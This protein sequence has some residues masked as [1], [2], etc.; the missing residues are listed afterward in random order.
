M[1]LWI[2]F[3][4]EMKRGWMPEDCWHAM[5]WQSP[6]RVRLIGSSPTLKGSR[7]LGMI[8]SMWVAVCGCLL[9]ALCCM[10]I[11]WGTA[12]CKTG[13][14]Q[15]KMEKGHSE[16]TVKGGGEPKEGVGKGW[17]ERCWRRVE[18]R[19]RSSAN[20]VGRQ[21]AALKMRAR[22][23]FYNNLIEGMMVI[24]QETWHVPIWLNRVRGEW[25]W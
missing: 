16:R 23:E 3:Y 6:L 12:E 13:L 25:L 20:L 14:F 7:W 8:R 19:S 24:I 1:F 18:K 15:V 2:H 10:W 17:R 22:Q 11:L 9:A 4:A 21:S 5:S